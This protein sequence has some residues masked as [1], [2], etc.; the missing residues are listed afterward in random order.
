MSAVNIPKRKRGGQKE[1]AESKYNQVG[2]AQ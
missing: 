1:G 2:L